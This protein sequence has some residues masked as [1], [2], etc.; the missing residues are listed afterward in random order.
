MRILLIRHG[1]PEYVNDSL[2]EKGRKEAHM[3]ASRL[4][5]ERIEYV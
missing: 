4:V 1:D 5:N 2:T 3:L